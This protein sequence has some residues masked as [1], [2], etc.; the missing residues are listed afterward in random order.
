MKSDAADDLT[1]TLAGIHVEEG[2][3]SDGEQDGSDDGSTGG[4]GSEPRSFMDLSALRH[5]GKV[6]VGVRLD[7]GQLLP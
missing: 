5:P 6:H 2:E 4:G 3:S 7:R 1:N